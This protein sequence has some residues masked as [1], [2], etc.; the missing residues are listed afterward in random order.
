MHNIKNTMLHDQSHFSSLPDRILENID[1]TGRQC[2]YTLQGRVW[3]RVPQGINLSCC[4]KRLESVVC[5]TAVLKG[6]SN[7]Y[8]L[9]FGSATPCFR[10]V[11]AAASLL[12][13]MPSCCSSWQHARWQGRTRSCS[14]NQQDCKSN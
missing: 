2:P 4:K 8:L 3:Y 6:H 5:I 14:Q 7:K 9:A 12:S 10:A 13:T 1:G 11:H